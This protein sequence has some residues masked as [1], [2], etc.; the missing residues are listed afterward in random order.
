[1]NYVFA[2]TTFNFNYAT[3]D[4]NTGLYVRASIYDLTTGTAVLATTVVMTNSLDG[5]YKGTYSGTL[6]H[7]YLVVALVFTDNTY[8]TLD[9]SR[10]PGSSI[11]QNINSSNTT[12]YFAY[13]TFDQNSGLYIAGNVYDVTSGNTFKSQVQMTNVIAGVYWGSYTGT[14]NKTY[15]VS[16]LVYTD[17]TYSTVDTTRAP[18]SDS[19]QV[20]NLS[21]VSGS[22]TDPGVSNVVNGV[23]YEI[24]G[25]NL[26]GTFQPVVNVLQQATLIG[27]SLQ[28][29]L[30]G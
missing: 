19:F 4:Q 5:V 18:A 16:Q 17:N 10:A 6:G 1:M 28:A 7:T 13:A 11:Y 8:S 21:L 14:L 26:V 3:F 2:A 15:L 30:V 20:W 22:S 23:A 12:I 9:T 29:T 27:Q 24:A 25:V